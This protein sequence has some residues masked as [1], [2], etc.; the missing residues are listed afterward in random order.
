MRRL[1]AVLLGV[2]ATF[3]VTAVATAAKPDMVT[4]RVDDTNTIQ[5]DGF[6]LSDHVFGTVKHRFWDDGAG[7]PV[8]ELNSISL[9]HVTTNPTTGESITTRDVGVDSIRFSPDGSAT[10]A[11]IGLVGR[12]VVP[13]QGLVA[14]NTGRLVLFFEGPDDEEPDVI[15][16]SGQK[17]DLEAA[18]CSVLAP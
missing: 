17:D 4:D 10:L 7:N 11:I 9:R 12:I 14:A 8:R 16:E 5:C 3:A 18:V 6:T 2:A 13:G 1:M 15:F